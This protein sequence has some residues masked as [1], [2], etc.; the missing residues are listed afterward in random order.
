MINFHMNVHLCERYW[1]YSSSSKKLQNQNAERNFTNKISLKNYKCRSR[2]HI[3]Q[4]QQQKYV[5]TKIL[6][7]VYMRRVKINFFT[8]TDADCIVV[9]SW[10]NFTPENEFCILYFRLPALLLKVKTDFPLPKM[11]MKICAV[12]VQ[13][14]PKCVLLCI[15]MCCCCWMWG[16]NST[17]KDERKGNLVENV[18]LWASVLQNAKLK[19][20]IQNI[21]CLYY[22]KSWFTSLFT[23]VV[24]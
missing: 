3:L 22:T 14:V 16:K 1:S 5:N 8:A 20:E 10:Q 9:R 11:K 15:R 2:L 4:Q 6:F 17:K 7:S 23:F 19:N 24:I 18:M 12:L 21:F 13:L